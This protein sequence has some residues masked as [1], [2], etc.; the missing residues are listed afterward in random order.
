MGQIMELRGHRGGPSTAPS[1]FVH[2]PEKLIKTGG[3]GKSP[4]ILVETPKRIHPW[5]K[6]EAVIT[7]AKTQLRVLSNHLSPWLL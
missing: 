2:Y 6:N 5:N 7:G 3:S 1:L 4:K